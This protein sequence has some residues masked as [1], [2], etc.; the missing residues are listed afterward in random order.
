VRDAKQ[1]IE[2][3]GNAGAAKRETI[4]T[5][6]FKPKQVAATI[7]KFANRHV[8]LAF[9]IN[10]NSVGESAELARPSKANPQIFT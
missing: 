1:L 3:F 6:I 10:F 4:F 2:C 8:W 9:P 5:L 7:A